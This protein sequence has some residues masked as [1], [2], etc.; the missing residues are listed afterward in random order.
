MLK[1]V[2]KIKIN[3]DLSQ[4]F[5]LTLFLKKQNVGYRPKKAKIFDK[6]EVSKFMEE[7]PDQIYLLIKVAT[8]FGLAGACR[9]EELCK[10]MVDHIEDKGNLIVVKIPDSK[11]NT[12]RIFVVSNET[13]KGH[14]LQLYHKYANLRKPSTPHKRFFVLY[15]QGTCGTQC[16]G[17]NSFGKMPSKI[18]AYL[19]LKNPEH[20]TGHSF[21]R[22]SA[23]MLADSGAGITNVKRLGGWKST[24]VAES[25]IDDSTN[26]KKDMS[27]KILATNNCP[28]ALSQPS[29]SHN[30]NC[31]STSQC[32]S[33]RTISHPLNELTGSAITLQ[34]V[35]NCSFVI[36][37]I[38]K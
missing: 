36:N 14:Y 22:S 33:S 23:T 25:Y 3:L 24:T 35:S 13:N 5:K 7:A 16:I 4:Y 21:R 12:S 20:Y 28:S 17:I 27:N 38:N 31:P 2:L 19:Q 37:V 6:I 9:R 26:Q 34:N 30:I 32:L 15:Q 29:S 1:S 18:A 8:I 10:I 11:N